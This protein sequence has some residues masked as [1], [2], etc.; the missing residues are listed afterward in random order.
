MTSPLARSIAVLYLSRHLQN[1]R[2]AKNSY[3]P[4]FL[5]NSY[6]HEHIL[7]LKKKA[8]EAPVAGGSQTAHG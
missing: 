3:N 6:F 7:Q 8:G 2:H 1:K 5:R 4:V